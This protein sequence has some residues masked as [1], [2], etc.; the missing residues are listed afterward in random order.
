[1]TLAVTTWSRR[2][3]AIIAFLLGE[4]LLLVLDHLFVERGRVHALLDKVVLL[5][6]A[7]ACRSLTWDDRC[8][9]WSRLEGVVHHK[10]PAASCFVIVV[11]VVKPAFN[12]LEDRHFLVQN[13]IFS[14]PIILVWHITITTICRCWCLLFRY[15]I[16][17]LSWVAWGFRFRII[18]IKQ[19]VKLFLRF[20]MYPVHSFLAW[21]FS[22]HSRC[23]LFPNVTLG[24][25]TPRL[26]RL[27]F[28]VSVFLALK[29]F[30]LQF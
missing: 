27:I 28:T 10:W 21:L 17:M 19:A 11:L 18:V 4:G 12:L 16:K 24:W 2:V 25:T 8:L 6:L 1:M 26:L 29:V 9:W 13:F 30:F 5:M 3:I 23:C 22:S 15:D 7:W 20:E 14:I